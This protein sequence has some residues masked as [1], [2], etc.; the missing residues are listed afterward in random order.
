MEEYIGSVWHKLI[1]RQASLEY[2][3]ASIK[4]A[5]IGPELSIYFRA[6]GGEAGKLVEPSAHRFTPGYQ[7]LVDKLAGRLRFTPAW[8]DERSLRLPVSMALFPEQSLNEQAYFWLTALGAQLSQVRHWS[9]D[10]QRATQGLLSQRRGLA[11][12]YRQLCETYCEL[13]RQYYGHKLHSA[14]HALQQALL[15]PGSVE[16]LPKESRQLLP[17]M[18]WLYPSPLLDVAGAADTDPDEVPGSSPDKQKKAPIGRKPAQRTDDEKQ[19]DGLLVF[20]LESLFSWTEHVNVDRPQEEDL[21][22]DVAAAADDLDIITLSR[23][24]RASAGKIRFDLDL[25]SPASDDLAVGDGI[26]LPEW[27]FRKQRLRPDYC[28][29]QPMLADDAEN[30]PL[31]HDLRNDVRSISRAF[32]QL[33]PAKQWQNRQ[34]QGDELDLNQWIQHITQTHQ[35]QE[36][37]AC[38]R[39]KQSCYR[40]LSCLLLADLSM[41]TDC[42][43]D[44]NTRV[45]DVIRQAMLVFSESLSNTG[46]QLGIYGFSS[47]RNKQIRYHI[48]KNFDEPYS[49]YVRGRIMAIKPGFYTRMGSAIRQSTEILKLQKSEQKLLLVIS[50]GKPNDIDQYEGRYGIEDTRH[51]FLQ[52]KREGIK[53][54][55]VTIDS[56]ANDYLPYI[57][58]EKGFCIVTDPT[59]LIHILPKLY[60]QLTQA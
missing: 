13:R 24:R 22:D 48:L 49:G 52:A 37:A 4:L 2:P 30:I 56:E 53:P 58:G 51:A 31:P 12:S 28:L 57:F 3:E 26:R 34:P 33:N 44:N 8:Q 1:T 11:K 21:D 50:D 5:D 7:R 43:L 16:H 35:G 6:L 47:V 38:F 39:A 18:L 59:R 27:D 10:N 60:I 54:F 19:T 23:Q 45:I 25:P 46:D 32:A 40:D 15:Q 14:E 17:V 42:A 55:C 9:K 41:S 29:L 20:K 36:E